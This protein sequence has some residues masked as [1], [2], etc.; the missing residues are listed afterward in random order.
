MSQTW[1]VRGGKCAPKYDDI[2]FF[3]TKSMGNFRFFFFAC[4]CHQNYDEKI[5]RAV[6]CTFVR[7]PKRHKVGRNCFLNARDNETKKE[8]ALRGIH[9]IIPLAHDFCILFSNKH[10]IDGGVSFTLK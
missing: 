4:V 3:V 10:I 5:V 7:V 8:L 2:K 9:R 6:E 1:E